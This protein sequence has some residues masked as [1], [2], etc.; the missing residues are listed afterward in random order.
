MPDIFKEIIEASEPI[1]LGNP[2]VTSA[3]TAAMLDHIL[4]D[5]H[6]VLRR[7][8]EFEREAR[9]LLDLYKRTNGGTIGLLRAGRGGRRAQSDDR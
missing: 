9:P 3:D 1:T 2:L 4:T 6:E 7:L 8:E 5:V